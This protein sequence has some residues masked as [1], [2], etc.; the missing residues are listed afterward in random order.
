MQGGGA[1]RG[2]PGKVV[3]TAARRGYTASVARHLASALTPPASDTS[4]S[5]PARRFTYAEGATMRIPL[6]KVS[7]A[8][9][10]L[11]SLLAVAGAAALT[12]A[13]RRQPPQEPPQVHV[14]KKFR[15]EVKRLKVE[16]HWIEK[17]GTPGASLHVVIRNK[18]ALAVTRV[19]VTISDLTVS[20]SSGVF[21]DVEA[22]PVIEPYGTEEFE[23]G[24]TN[25]ID[26]APFVISAAFYADGTEEGRE[27]LLKEAHQ[28]REEEK[29]KRAEKKG[30]PER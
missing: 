20:R 24:L 1:R 18:S 15:S 4:T 11:L 2:V 10:L 13:R 27:E 12:A 7:L 17:E 26:D 14:P 9:L 3:D 19:S 21:Y 30:G 28:S 8:S 23:I 22:E 5:R 6:R 25:F 29:A 16:S